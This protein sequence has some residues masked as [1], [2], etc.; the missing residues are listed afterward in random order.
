MDSYERVLGVRE[1]QKLV[2]SIM[3]KLDK[4]YLPTVKDKVMKGKKVSAKKIKSL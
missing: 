1:I 3:I 2:A 4:K